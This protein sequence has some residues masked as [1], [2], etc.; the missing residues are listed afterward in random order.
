MF[1]YFGKGFD[2]DWN[3]FINWLQ[4][5]PDSKEKEIF[6]YQAKFYKEKWKEF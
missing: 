3:A 6:L 5:Q 2:V 4:Y 1:D